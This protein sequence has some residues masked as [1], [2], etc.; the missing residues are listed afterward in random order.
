METELGAHRVRA[1]GTALLT[2]WYAY[3]RPLGIKAHPSRGH[4]YAYGGAKVLIRFPPK[5]ADRTH[6]KKKGVPEF[7]FRKAGVYAGRGPTAAGP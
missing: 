2:F 7:F 6:S 5:V 3:K 1:L 4:I